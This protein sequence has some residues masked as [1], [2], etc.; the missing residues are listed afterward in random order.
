MTSAIHGCANASASPPTTVTSSAAEAVQLLTGSGD[1]FSSAR[2]P[3]FSTW[4]V[5]ATPAPVASIPAPRLPSGESV[6]AARN[7][8]TGTRSSVCSKSHPESTPGILSAKNSAPASTPD[9][10]STQGDCATCSAGGRSS[11]PSMP[12]RPRPKTVRYTRMPA[13]QASRMPMAKSWA[14]VMDVPSRVG[15]IWRLTL[16]D[17]SIGSPGAPAPW[18]P[19]GTERPAKSPIRSRPSHPGPHA[20]VDGRAVVLRARPAHRRHRDLVPPCAG[21]RFARRAHGA[22]G[23]GPEGPAGAQCA[24]AATHLHAHA[25]R[26]DLARRQPRRAGDARGQGRADRGPESRCRVLRAFRRQRR[27]TQGLVGAFGRIRSRGGR[28]LALRGGAHAKPQSRCGEP[29]RDA[30]RRGRR[31]ERQAVDREVGHAATNP[32]RCRAKIQIP[33]FPAARRQHRPAAGVHAAARQGVAAGTRRERRCGVRVDI[34]VDTRGAVTMFKNTNKPSSRDGQAVD[35]LIGPQ[36]TL[37]G[38]LEFSGGLYVEGRIIGRV[39]ATEGER[40]VLVLGENGSIEGEVRAPVVMI[41]GRLD[42][43]VH[44]TERVELAAKARVTGNVHYRTVEMH[45]G[46]QLTGRLV[47]ADAA[48]ATVLEAPALMAVSAA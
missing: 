33:L 29:G 12:A 30:F 6:A 42:G 48:A 7:A 19:R 9:T 22:D 27:R 17:P 8:P 37:R 38:D 36:V 44:A 16:P 3:A 15:R 41:D 21:G 40:A 32:R 25:L 2:E 43:D 5:S 20:R 26:P 46:A 35:T 28:Q 13:S 18:S 24:I 31:A 47:H 1:V 23:A 14:S 39:T 4:L 11:H 34:E 45:A 10:P